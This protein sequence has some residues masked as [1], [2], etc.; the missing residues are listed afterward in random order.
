MH[1]S[2]N[3]GT[4]SRASA[5]APSVP[6]QKSF[7]FQLVSHTLKCPQMSEKVCPRSPKMMLKSSWKDTRFLKQMK[8]GHLTK[9][10]VF[11]MV[12]AHTSISS[13]C[14][15]HSQIAKKTALGP[16][17][18]TWW[19][20]PSKNHQTEPKLAPRSVPMPPR[21]LQKVVKN[22]KNPALGS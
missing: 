14:D 20:K 9:T 21:N 6:L 5:G 10:S 22:H 16:R 1:A 17:L 19:P 7:K 18:P 15:F 2:S 4:P 3:G 13:G 8:K 11:T 12:S